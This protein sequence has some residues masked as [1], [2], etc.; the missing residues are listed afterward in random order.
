[1]ED[2]E[3]QLKEALARKEE[4]ASL[5]AKVFAAIALSRP[6][7]RKS[8]RWEAVAASLLI[9]AGLWAQHEQTVRERVAGEAAKAR[10][11]AA[12]KVTVT[13]LSK[14]QRT[15]EAATEDE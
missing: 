4:P 12:L 5:E 10:L 9:S 11:Q 7:L 14:I 2:F 15:V 8:W 3:Q 6:P 1:M 13:E